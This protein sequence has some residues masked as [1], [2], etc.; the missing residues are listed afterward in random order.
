LYVISVAETAWWKVQYLGL[1]SL[2]IEEV[3]I[4]FIFTKQYAL[5]NI[6]LGNCEFF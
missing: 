6:I 5:I 4:L 2:W 3:F 1:I